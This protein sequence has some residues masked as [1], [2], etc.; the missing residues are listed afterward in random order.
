LVNP[1]EDYINEKSEIISGKIPNYQIIK[2]QNGFAAME[3][4]EEELPTVVITADEMPMMNGAEL[5][6]LIRN[7]DK[8][9][10]VSIIVLADE[11]NDEVNKRYESHI[12][13]HILESKISDS[14]L[15]HTI[16]R[17]LK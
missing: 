5:I 17:L 12:V 13:D 1:S 2:A 15:I 4:I 14:E 10:S 7:K 6:K 9:F 3:Y 8:Y 16:N 11:V